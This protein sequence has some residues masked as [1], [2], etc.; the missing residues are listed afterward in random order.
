MSDSTAKLTVEEILSQAT[1]PAYIRTTTVRLLLR[2]DLLARHDELER[3]LDAAVQGDG[4]ENR[5]PQAP[6]VS[7]Q[8]VDLEAEIDAA[9]VT[10]KFQSIG[11]R[12]W[13]D[14][15]AAHP[16]TKEQLKAFN[17][18]DHNP[19]TFP[20]AAIAASCVEPAM[21][22]DDVGR[23]ERALNDTQFNLLLVRCVEAN[24]GGIDTPKSAVASGIARLV[25]GRSANTAVP[26]ASPA[27]SSLAE[28]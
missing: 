9:K 22:V 2:Q 4:L 20:L 24:T 18:I 1:D 5:H 11:H 26:A 17:R 12:A 19:E 13:A 27:Q 7:Q 3:E 16:P 21:T 14:L 23:L 10:F 15:M 25:N 28:P 6:N 8:L